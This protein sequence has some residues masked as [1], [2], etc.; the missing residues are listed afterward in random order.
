MPCLLQPLLCRAMRWGEGSRAWAAPPTVYLLTTPDSYISLSANAPPHFKASR[1][2]RGLAAAAWMICA[3][4]SHQALYASERPRYILS[5]FRPLD[6]SSRPSNNHLQDSHLMTM[7]EPLMLN[8]ISAWEQGGQQQ[9]SHEMMRILVDG[10]I[11]E[12]QS[13]QAYSW[14]QASAH[15]SNEVANTPSCM[16]ADDLTHL[17]IERF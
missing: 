8:T 17:C 7:C 14:R 4:N 5:L 10:L 6:T 16:Q 1:R 3:V 12:E 13:A 15:R 11:T 9:C 2:S